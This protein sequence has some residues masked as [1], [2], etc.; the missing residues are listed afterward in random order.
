MLDD[1]YN[2]AETIAIAQK[3][4]IPIR[5]RLVK[6][7]RLDVAAKLAERVETFR[8]A[9]A[10]ITHEIVE[11]VFAGD[12][13]KMC[14]ATWQPHPHDDG[15]STGEVRID[16]LIRGQVFVGVPDVVGRQPCRALPINPAALGVSTNGC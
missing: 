4:E 11:P 8:R 10:G 5:D 16:E 7:Q 1:P 13:D 6:S 14:D 2:I 9:V 3:L 15:V 12:D